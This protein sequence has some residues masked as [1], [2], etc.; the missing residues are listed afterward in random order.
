MSLSRT[1]FHFAR[2]LV[3]LQLILIFE[4]R[5]VDFNTLKHEKNFPYYQTLEV[6]TLPRMLISS[7]TI[8]KSVK[9][10]KLKL[11]ITIH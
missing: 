10:F 6:G 9:G 5:I 7:F 1:S 4:H 8:P 2:L 3:W 11:A